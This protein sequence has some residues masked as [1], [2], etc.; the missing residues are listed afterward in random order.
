MVTHIIKS[1]IEYHGD[2]ATDTCGTTNNSSN[3]QL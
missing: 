1:R 2:I 3:L